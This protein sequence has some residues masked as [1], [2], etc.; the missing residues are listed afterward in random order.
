M[1]GAPPVSSKVLILCHTPGLTL[2]AGSAS[3]LG[4]LWWWN[5]G[6]TDLVMTQVCRGKWEQGRSNF[7]TSL[8]LFLAKKKFIAQYSVKRMINE[9]I[10]WSV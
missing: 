10:L 9:K 2:G 5:V 6:H 1:G 4:R 8:Q 7:M 3:G